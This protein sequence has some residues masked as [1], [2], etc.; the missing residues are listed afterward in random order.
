MQSCRLVGVEPVLY[1]TTVA[2]PAMGDPAM[3]LTPRDFAAELAHER[4][5]TR[6]LIRRR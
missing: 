2:Q 3:A 4:G 5:A 1:M 6:K